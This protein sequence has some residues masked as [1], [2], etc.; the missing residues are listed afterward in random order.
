MSQQPNPILS[1][2]ICQGNSCYVTHM[3]SIFLIIKTNGLH[4]VFSQYLL[5]LH[6]IIPVNLVL[7]YTVLFL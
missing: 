4:L 5:P 6:P 3:Q 2:N 7:S 1:S